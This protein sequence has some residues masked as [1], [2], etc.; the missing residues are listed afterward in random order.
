MNDVF[1][2]NFIDDVSAAAGD[3]V[4]F[5]QFT[6]NDPAESAPWNFHLSSEPYGVAGSDCPT[7]AV[8]AQLVVDTM[9]AFATPRIC[10][11][12]G[13]GCDLTAVSTTNIEAAQVDLKVMPNPASV[14]VRFEAKENIQSIYVY[15]LTGRLVKAHTD[16][17]GLQFTMQR[18]NLA[19]GLYVAQVRFEKGF[20]NQKLSFN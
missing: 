4:G 17:N 20:V 9:L 6:S 2:I 8:A 13:L 3:V 7:D 15:D 11:A 1:D 14:E 10:L 16:I 5:Y 12:L 19:N 18:N